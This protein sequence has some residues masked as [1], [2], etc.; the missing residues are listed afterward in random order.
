MAL[1]D[2]D[3]GGKRIKAAL[4]KAQ[5]E[6]S[7]AIDTDRPVSRQHEIEYYGYYGYPYYWAGSYLWGAYPYPYPYPYPFPLSGPRRAS[8]KSG[9]GTGLGRRAATLISG[10]RP[11]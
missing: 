6:K 10:V 3:W 1:R 7:P 11:P 5:V 9:T 2:I 8:S 4:T